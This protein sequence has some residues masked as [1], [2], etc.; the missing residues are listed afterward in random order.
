ML[1]TTFG[2]SHLACAAAIA[3]AD[4]MKSEELVKNAEKMG[5]AIVEGI[6]G[7]SGIKDLRC[8]CCHH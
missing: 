7:T 8:V 5:Q 3:V 1:G 4:V 6:K 2:G